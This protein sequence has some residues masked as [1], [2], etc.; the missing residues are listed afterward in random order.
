MNMKFPV[1]D[2]SRSEIPIWR[3]ILVMGSMELYA[4]QTV[5]SSWARDN[6]LLDSASD[7]IFVETSQLG[8]LTNVRTINPRTKNN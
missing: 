1:N 2:K 3:L 8:L 5:R 7:L 6:I 4:N